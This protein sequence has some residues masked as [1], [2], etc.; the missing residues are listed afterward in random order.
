MG[1]L[2]PVLS[3][4][5]AAGAD[6]AA[7]AE[8]SRRFAA[9]REACRRHPFFS[10]PERRAHLYALAGALLANRGR[11][12][13]ALRSDFMV[14]PDATADLVD[15][16]GPLSRA[17]S[18]ARQLARWMRPERRR[19][20]RIS[21]GTS[22]AY[23]SWQ[24][25]GVAGVIVPWNFP[26]DLSFGPLTDMLAAGNRVILKMS[27]YTP[28]CGQLAAEIV[29]ETFDAD[30][31]TVLNGGPELGRAFAALR[32]DHLLFTGN[33]EV[34]RQVAQVAAA[35][36]VPV[37]LELGGKNPAIFA[38]DAV[39]AEHVELALGVKLVNN[40]QMCVSVDHCLVPRAQL[41]TFVSLARAYFGRALH[42]YSRTAH[43]PGIIS[44]RHFE[45]QLQLLE[46]ARAAGARIV[47]L[48]DAGAV[49]AATRRM[50]LSLVIDPDPQLRLMREEI[51]GPLLPV[52]P[53]DSVDEV[54]ETLK[55]GERPLGLYLYTADAALVERFRRETVSGGLGVNASAAQ[56]AVDDLGFGG[57][58]RSGTGRH[59]GYDGF[60]EFSNPRGM[61]V[62]GRGG[63]FKN[64]LPPFTVRK[65]RQID[66]L[67]WLRRLQLGIARTWHR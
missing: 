5:P 64:F 17:L 7:L 66:R 16:G 48:D 15:I 65:Q 31:V 39:T 13:A 33:V 67:F 10:L 45:R 49:D 22:R 34:G 56:A 37:T 36:L 60:R 54:I 6:A 46:E 44:P 57:I 28:A 25:K 35:N 21:F 20:D 4:D 40:G 12:R 14:H 1:A 53:Y 2:P 63:G 38:G 61:F 29:H 24:P 47:Q 55:R 8:L 62:K 18:N 50:P 23:V 11:L 9:Q 32:W 3:V 58:G 59:H 19:I 41:D 51:F 26:F 27:E 52:I 42:D 43:C 30:H